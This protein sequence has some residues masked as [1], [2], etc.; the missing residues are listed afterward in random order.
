MNNTQHTIS[1]SP[2][3]KQAL[4]KFDVDINDED[5]LKIAAFNTYLELSQSGESLVNLTL[6]KH[7]RIQVTILIEISDSTEK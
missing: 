6:K 2:T 3:M 1:T 5:V 4:Y 7:S